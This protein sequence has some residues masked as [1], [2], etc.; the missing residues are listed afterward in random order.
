VGQH[1]SSALFYCVHCSSTQSHANHSVQPCI[2]DL[3]VRYHVI[4]IWLRCSTAKVRC[5]T[6]I[7][8]HAELVNHSVQL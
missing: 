3:A 6:C 2:F 7:V 4:I 1:Y 5:R 8:Q